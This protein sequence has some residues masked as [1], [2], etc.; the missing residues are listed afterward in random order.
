MKPLVAI[1]GRENVGKSTLFNRLVGKNKAV[2]DDLPGLT[3][4]RNYAEVISEGKE[5]IL[6][7]TGGFEPFRA[8]NITSQIRE[9]TQ[10]AIEEADTIIF[11]AD[12]QAGLNP[13]DI[14]IVRMLAV[15]RK[16]L[17]Y[18]VNKIDKPKQKDHVAEFFQL[19][20]DKLIPISAKNNLGISELKR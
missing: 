16:P 5:F 13:T 7:D 6:V 15:T 11:L 17:L 4:D 10:L 18:V 3:R 14:E 1:V 20:V 2:I 12:G 19:G 9:Q 8:D